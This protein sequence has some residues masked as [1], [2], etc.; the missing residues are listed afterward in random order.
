MEDFVRENVR[1]LKGYEPGFQPK[2]KDF[3]KLNTNENPYPPSPEVIEALKKGINEDLKKYPDP[4]ADDLKDMVAVMNQVTPDEVL[5]GNGSDEVLSIIFRCFVTEGTRVLITDPTYTLF[6]VLANIQGAQVKKIPLDDEFSLPKSI[7]NETAGLT[8]IPQPNAQTGTFFDR[9]I[10]EELAVACAGVLVI[11]EAYIDFSA[12]DCLDV[13]KKF[14]NVIITRS[15][16]KSYS[17]AG[18]RI[19]Y[20]LA[21]PYFIS[22]MMKVKDSY[23]VS[24]LAIIAGIAA[25]KDRDYFETCSSKIIVE[26]N[27]ITKKL[28]E[29]GLNPYPSQANFVLVKSEN[30]PARDLYDKLKERKILVRYFDAPKLKDCIRISIGT[31]KEMVVLITEIE[32]IL[33]DR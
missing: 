19:G 1:K 3:V 11:D 7:L 27:F 6:E 17:L 25:L 30:Y 26:R 8:L 24:R 33:N 9:R 15:F 4:R 12:S 2:E 21:N 32:K 13:Y 10:L 31:H 29:M 16:S 28:K 20:A 5:I 22:E 14:E 18:M 23:N